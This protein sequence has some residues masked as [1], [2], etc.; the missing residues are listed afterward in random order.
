MTLWSCKVK[1]E[2][3]VRAG[4]LKMAVN[5]SLI[6]RIAKFFFFFFFSEQCRARRTKERFTKQGNRLCYCCNLYNSRTDSAAQFV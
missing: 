4:P 3:N 5:L 6:D 1:K 2:D